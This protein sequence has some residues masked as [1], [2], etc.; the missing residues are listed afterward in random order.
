MFSALPPYNLNE[1]NSYNL[2]NDFIMLFV[3]C[4]YIYII[5][6]HPC[7]GCK[8][9][10]RAIRVAPLRYRITYISYHIIHTYI[11]THVHTGHTYRIVTVSG[12]VTRTHTHHVS[13]RIMYTH[14]RR[15]RTHSGSSNRQNQILRTRTRDRTANRNLTGT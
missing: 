10:T 8:C 7:R 9:Y 1:M 11:H 2:F 14:G 12:I 4:C 13:T 3:I 6:H 15:T 5:K